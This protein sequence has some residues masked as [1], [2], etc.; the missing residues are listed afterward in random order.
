[1]ILAVG[2]PVL[3]LVGRVR[4]VLVEP[5]MIAEYSYMLVRAL[6]CCFTQRRPCSWSAPRRA[7]ACPARR[8]VDAARETEQKQQQHRCHKEANPRRP[9][10]NCSEVERA[11]MTL[12]RAGTR[13]VVVEEGRRRLG[14][15]LFSLFCLPD[16]PERCPLSLLFSAA[17]LLPFSSFRS[18]PCTCKSDGGG[19]Q[20]EGTY[21]PFSCLA[22]SSNRP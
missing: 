20:R 7:A 10:S 8:R 21:H 19:R 9:R 4:M 17:L 11:C 6:A 18:F 16:L 22:P 15:A 1:M 14:V 3:A 5:L 12:L 13:V 2:D